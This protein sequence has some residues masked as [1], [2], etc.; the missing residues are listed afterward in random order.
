[1]NLYL[2]RHGE[3]DANREQR[4]LGS[5]DI[6]LNQHG[7]EQA[8][9]LR[10][11]LPAHLD[12]VFV[13]PLLRARQTVQIAFPNSTVPITVVDDLRE[14]GVGVFEG[15][16]QEE[17]KLRYPALWQGNCTRSWRSAP[18]GGETIEDVAVRLI[19]FLNTLMA[20]HAG[21]SVALIAH[22]FVA[23]TIRALALRNFGDFFVWQLRN[24]EVLHVSL[25]QHLSLASDEVDAM[26]T[27]AA[28]SS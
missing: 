11:A 8:E 23:K 7:R 2:A 9:R 3:T 19:T 18:T 4:Y 15:L 26:L 6:G 22:G 27:V 28:T 20:A 12:H 14:R 13:S 21:K 24:G 16:T 1:M 25:T 17:A 10:D 5:L